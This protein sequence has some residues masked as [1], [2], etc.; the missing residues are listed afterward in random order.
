MELVLSSTVIPLLFTSML[1]SKRF[2]F[3]APFWSNVMT[4]RSARNPVELRCCACALCSKYLFLSRNGQNEARLFF[5]PQSWGLYKDRPAGMAEVRNKNVDV[6]EDRERLFL[7]NISSPNS[8]HALSVMYYCFR[9]GEDRTKVQSENSNM[10]T[11]FCH[12]VVQSL[13]F[14]TRRMCVS[15]R[16][17]L[18]QDDSLGET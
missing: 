4:E 15:L 2:P 7:L 8:S 18:W 11:M 17:V 1:R 5:H 16:L 10:F 6:F 13:P 3:S 12:R 14:G 9:K